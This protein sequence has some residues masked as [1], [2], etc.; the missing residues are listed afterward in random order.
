ML[1]DDFTLQSS[2]KSLDD[3]TAVQCFAS[4]HIVPDND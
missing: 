4:V 1:F 2:K 3:I